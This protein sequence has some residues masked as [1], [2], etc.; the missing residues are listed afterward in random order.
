MHWTGESIESH[1]WVR[2]DQISTVHKTDSISQEIVAVRNNIK[3]DTFSVGVGTEGYFIRATDD[4]KEKTKRPCVLFIHGGPHAMTPKNTFD[5]L[6][7]L[8]LTLGYSICIVNY[9]GSIGY[10]L[11]NIEKL[12]GNVFD[13][14]VSD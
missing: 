1:E 3:I 6:Q 11:E 9:R 5:K 7:L 14:D 12:S 8:W 10:S 4:S 2:I 13:M